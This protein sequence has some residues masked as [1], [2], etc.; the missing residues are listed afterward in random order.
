MGRRSVDDAPPLDVVSAGQI[1]GNHR[2]TTINGERHRLLGD[3]TN[4]TA[5]TTL[6]RHTTSRHRVMDSHQ[7]PASSSSTPRDK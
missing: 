2:Y 1:Q 7:A 3:S 4:L 6:R 5:L